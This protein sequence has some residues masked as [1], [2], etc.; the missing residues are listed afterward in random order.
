MFYKLQNSL[1]W[2]I[3]QYQNLVLSTQNAYRILASDEISGQCLLTI[4]VVGKNVVFKMP[5]E[6]IAADNALLEQFSKQDVRTI[7]YYAC[8]ETMKP[9]SRIVWQQFNNKSNQMLFGVQRG[10]GKISAITA[11]EISKHESFIKEFNQLDAHTIGFTTATEQL[12]LEKELIKQA[13]N[14]AYNTE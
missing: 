13:R 8:L 14:D 7:I 10:K 4:Q 3:Q 5:P 2:L 1:T 6:E 12:I 9:K 11:D